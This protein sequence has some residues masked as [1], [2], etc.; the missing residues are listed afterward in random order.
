MYFKYISF[1]GRIWI[2]NL[3]FELLGFKAGWVFHLCLE[4]YCPAQVQ[5]QASNPEK[6]N[7]E[8]DWGWEFGLWAACHLN[9][10]DHPERELIVI[11]LQRMSNTLTFA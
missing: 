6:S 2:Y 10:I 4:L 11:R 9:F 8:R 1:C 7:I 3:V 5:S